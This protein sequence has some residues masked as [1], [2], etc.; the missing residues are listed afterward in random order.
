MVVSVPVPTALAA[1][2]DSG[3]SKESNWGKFGLYLRYR[4]EFVDDDAVA[5][6]GYASTLRT[7][8]H[9]TTPAWHDLK[10][11]IQFKD[12]SDLGASNQHNVSG[13]PVIADPPDTSVEQI[14]ARYDGLPDTGFILGRQEINL[15]EQRFVGAVGW[16]QNHQTMDSFRVIQKSIPRTT[17][18]YAYVGKANTITTRIDDMNTNLFNAGIDIM[19]AGTLTPFVYSIDYDSDTRASFSTISYGAR[20]QGECGIGDQW[21]IPY[22]AELAQQNDTGNNPGEVDAQYYRL[23]AKGK[24]ERGRRRQGRTGLPHGLLPPLLSR[25][26]E[27]D[28]RSGARRQR[29]VQ[30]PL[31]AGLRPATRL[32]RRRRFPRGHLQDLA[33][34]HLPV[35]KLG[36]AYRFPGFPGFGL[37]T[38]ARSVRGQAT[39]V[40]ESRSEISMLSPVLR[41][42][43]DGFG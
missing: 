43:V 19:E 23:E 26:R 28:L 42:W 6:S 39:R 14:L 3:V 34:V 18:T 41:R 4:F 10:A 27:H 30:G 7:V 9:Y 25:V 36:T 13:R 22:H 11:F 24:R 29:V 32:L 38:T 8:V 5:D 20:W 16:R 33:L 1:E 40:R 21:K 12:V 31:E 2:G 35:L 37:R 15:E 17:W